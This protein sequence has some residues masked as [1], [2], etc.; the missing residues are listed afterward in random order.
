MIDAHTDDYLHPR[1]DMI[2]QAI[3]LEQSA[4]SMAGKIDAIRVAAGA[5]RDAAQAA[6]IA[7]AKAGVGS[8]RRLDAY[9]E[10]AGVAAMIER[11][12]CP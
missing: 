1:A 7:M 2:L 3:A 12:A 11:M 10:A 4:K 8:S 9:S 6:R 5:E